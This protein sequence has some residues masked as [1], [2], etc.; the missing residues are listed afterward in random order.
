MRKFEQAAKQQQQQQGGGGVKRRN[1]LDS[2][3]SLQSKDERKEKLNCSSSRD[4]S[5]GRE[6]VAVA[7]E[8]AD[9]EKKAMNNNGM[10]NPPTTTLGSQLSSSSSSLQ[11]AAVHSNK[12]KRSNSMDSVDFKENAKHTLEGETASLMAQGRLSSI[13][14]NHVN[15]SNQTTINEEPSRQQQQ[16][17]DDDKDESDNDNRNNNNSRSLS[18]GNDKDKAISMSS[19]PTEQ[20]PRSPTKAKRSNA[21]RH[22]SGNSSDGSLRHHGKSPSSNKK[23]TATSTTES[24]LASSSSKPASILKSAT[25]RRFGTPKSPEKTTSSSSSLLRDRMRAFEQ[26]CDKKDG[27]GQK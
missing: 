9:M 21:T 16:Q 26:N 23:E 27:G 5:N 12:P 2:V 8:K 15:S 18:H 19:T 11:V 25:K 13:V 14:E 4:N 1:S 24:S 10:P 6:A 17:Q 7:V 20:S 22:D 3:A